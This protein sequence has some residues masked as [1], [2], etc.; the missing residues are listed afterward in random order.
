M[1]TAIFQRLSITY[2]ESLHGAIEFDLEPELLIEFKCSAL[3]PGHVMIAINGRPSF[4]RCCLSW[5]AML[6]SGWHR[7]CLPALFKIKGAAVREK[8][9]NMIPSAPK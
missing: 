9:L 5:L 2:I 8:V 4:A 7:Q 6:V 1:F 3:S